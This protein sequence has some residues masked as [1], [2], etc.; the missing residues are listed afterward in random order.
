MGATLSVGLD[1]DPHAVTSAHQNA[2][3][4][5]IDPSRM[6]LY[7]VSS[8]NGS[9]SPDGKVNELDSRKGEFDIIIANILLNPLMQLAQDII[10]YGKPGS[11]IGLS[12]ILTEQVI[13]IILVDQ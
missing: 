13:D 7:L 5:S 1:I 9:A 4:N 12:G 3:L 6:P 2:S 11:I 8:K 10:S